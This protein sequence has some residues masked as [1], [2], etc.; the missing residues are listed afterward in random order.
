MVCGLW[1]A[2]TIV[3]IATVFVAPGQLD[4]HGIGSILQM[5]PVGFLHVFI[6]G[7]LAAKLW[8]AG[9]LKQRQGVAAVAR[10]AQA[11]AACGGCGT[12]IGGFVGGTRYLVREWGVTGGYMLLALAAVGDNV[13]SAAALG[14]VGNHNYAWYLMLRC[15]VLTPVHL[16]LLFGLAHERDP[17]ARAF[18]HPALQQLGQLSYPVYMLQRSVYTATHAALDGTA[19]GASVANYAV[20]PLLLLACSF[21]ALHVLV[22]PCQRRWKETE[23]WLFG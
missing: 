14:D 9:R 2:A 19:V 22:L 16:V 5:T 23:K 11:A 18:T 17:I 15:G 13:F 4:A 1:P 10:D 6:S 3:P 12:C 8:A 7:M 21:A 20:A